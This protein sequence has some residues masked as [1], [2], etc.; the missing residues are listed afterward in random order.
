M[1]DAERASAATGLRLFNGVLQVVWVLMVVGTAWIVMLLPLMLA[2]KG[3]S[4]GVPGELEAPYTVE[5]S[6]GARVT[7]LGG[8]SSDSEGAPP[9]EL[10]AAPAVTG[11]VRIGQG[12]F[13]ALVVAAV[14]T[15][16][17]VGL[18]WMGFVSLRR[19]VRSALDGT[20]FL[21]G[22]VRR[23]RLLAG[24]IAGCGVVAASERVALEWAL[25]SSTVRVGRIGPSWWVFV[26][27][28]L[29]VLAL[30]EVFKEGVRLREFEASAI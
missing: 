20:P 23:L 12:Q 9:A 3:G 24:S 28:A 4:F 5:F 17:A 29:G 19:V 6:D 30:A 18:A 25:A 13:D 2:G 27:G 21:E 7:Y 16:S 1:G 10:D 26:A 14:A 8:G 22:N 15:A 11:T